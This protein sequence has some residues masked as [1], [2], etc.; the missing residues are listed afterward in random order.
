M[1]VADW[2]RFGSGVDQCIQFWRVNKECDVKS[3]E[4]GNEIVESQADPL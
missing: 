2:V 1:R 3:D 4:V